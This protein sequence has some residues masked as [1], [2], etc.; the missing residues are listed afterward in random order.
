MK[1]LTDSRDP[2]TEWGAIYRDSIFLHFGKAA[3]YGLQLAFYRTLAIPTIAKVLVESGRLENDSDKRVFD[4]NPIMLELN[5]DE[6]DG[7]R[8]RKMNSAINRAHRGWS[9]SDEDY[10]YVLFSFIATPYRY[11]ADFGWR[12]PLM[13]EMDASH[14]FYQQLG[15]SNMATAMGMSQPVATG[16]IRR[17]RQL[18]G[19][20]T[21]LTPM[22]KRVTWFTPGQP[23]GA[24]YPRGY[25]ASEDGLHS[26]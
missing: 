11:L 22:P 5:W 8:G 23:A 24:V 9:I 21:S 20:L 17:A 14:M 4:T 12:R 1:P 26:R 15:E 6:P 7:E 19:R 13:V 2:A 10:R 25:T 18:R 16:H 3:Q